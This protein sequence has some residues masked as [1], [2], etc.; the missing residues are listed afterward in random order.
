[1]SAQSVLAAHAEAVPLAWRVGAVSVP[2]AS[3]VGVLGYPGF[4][5]ALEA[6]SEALARGRLAPPEAP[7]VDA[8]GGPGAVLAYARVRGGPSGCLL[9]SSAAARRVALALGVATDEVRAGF[10]WDLAVGSI[11]EAWWRAPLDR[12]WSRALAELDGWARALTPSGRLVAVWH[13]D[14]GGKRAERA[15]SQRFAHVEVVNRSGG[16]RVVTLRGPLAEV[17][18]PDVWRDWQG[19]DGPMRTMVGT[20]AGERLDAGTRA[21][22]QALGA[23]GAAAFEGARVLDLGCGSGVLSLRALRL[24]A[25]EVVALDDDLAAV[26]SS[27]AVLAGEAAGGAAGGA[28][29]VAWSDLTLDATDVAGMDVVLMNPPFHVGRRVVGALSEAFV[30]AAEATLRPDGRVWL[31]ANAA[32]PF[33]RLLSSWRGPSDVTPAGVRSYRVYAAARP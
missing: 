33:E 8:T 31:V 9:T 19:P 30:A 21:L 4:D 20:F 12:G 28:A 18:A 10:A 24:G 32:L 25:R 5:P 1:M 27:E 7:F 23:D 2:L 17:P 29:R 14:E 15:A 16:W 13:K 11:A 3:A 26:R 22:L 6:L